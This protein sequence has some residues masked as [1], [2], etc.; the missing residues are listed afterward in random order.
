MGAES[1]PASIVFL[2]FG[3]VPP[4]ESEPEFVLFLISGFFDVVRAHEALVRCAPGDPPRV[5]RIVAA[6]SAQF[7]RDRS[8]APSSDHRSLAD[9]WSDGQTITDTH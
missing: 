8:A 2:E 1:P 7:P 6:L 4:I 3:E 9:D 5:A